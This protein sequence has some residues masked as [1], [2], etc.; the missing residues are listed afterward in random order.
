MAVK[1]PSSAGP[2]ETL[3]PAH[4]RKNVHVG[5]A[6]QPGDE[7][8]C[9]VQVPVGFQHRAQRLRDRIGGFDDGLADGVV[10]IGAGG[11]QQ[12]PHEE[13]EGGH[14]EDESQ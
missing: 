4:H 1:P 2:N 10:E 6:D 5:H 3:R 7:H 9:E 11:L 12:E 13:Q 14:A 8:G